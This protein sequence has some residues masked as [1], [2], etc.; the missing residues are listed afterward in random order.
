[1]IQNINPS[2]VEILHID[3]DSA[4]FD[5]PYNG[6]PEPFF[7]SEDE[8]TI[9]ITQDVTIDRETKTKM[10]TIPKKKINYIRTTW[11]KT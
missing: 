10:W 6:S 3:M 1:M 5:F 7:L 4:S 11:K 8:D 9:Y 2:T